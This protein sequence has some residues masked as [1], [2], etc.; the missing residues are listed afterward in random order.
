MQRLT[1]PVFTLIVLLFAVALIESCA[2]HDLDVVDPCSDAVFSYKDDVQP[3]VATKCAIP[4]CHN[5]SLGPE[6]NWAVFAT[7]QERA[8]AG[9]ISYMIK[10][11]QMPP[12][13]SP[14]GPLTDEQITAIS[15]WADGGAQNN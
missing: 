6:R 13:S 15:C 10:T 9:D 7:F 14:A 3:I 4:D 1:Y 8:L 12:E 2:N 11:H 5:G